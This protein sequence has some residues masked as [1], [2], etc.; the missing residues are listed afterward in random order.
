MADVDDGWIRRIHERIQRHRPLADDQTLG[1]LRAADQPEMQG[2]RK[3]DRSEC[4]KPEERP[5]DDLNRSMPAQP[6]YLLT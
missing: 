2:E 1:E 5:G 4:E 3:P 6:P